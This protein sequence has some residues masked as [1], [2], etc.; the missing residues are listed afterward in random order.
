MPRTTRTF[1]A[2]AVPE[3]LGAKLARLQR[4]LAPEIPNARWSETSPFHMTL[5][6]LGDVADVD[7]KPVCE[8]VA[9]AAADFDPFELR[10]EGLGVFP[11]PARAR[12]AW[13]GLTGPGLTA[14]AE[15]RDRVSRAVTSTLSLPVD[16]R[17]SPHV[18]LGRL[19]VDRRNPLDLSPLLKHY[20][21]WSAGAFL[22]TEVITF[23][24]T[25]TPDGPVYARLGTAP[26]REGADRPGSPAPSVDPAE[27]QT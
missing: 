3:L 17:F 12:V 11:D 21:T 27:G 23:A 4:L 18:T 7:L 5:A 8:A 1:V 16:S 22:V 9:G 15:L 6:F 20:R 19:K 26:L 14:L 13:V 24:S 10:L 2:I 25:L